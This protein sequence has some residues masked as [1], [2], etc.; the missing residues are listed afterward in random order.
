VVEFEDCT[1]TPNKAEKKQQLYNQRFYENQLDPPRVNREN[2]VDCL[3]WLSK[4]VVSEE[5]VVQI[6]I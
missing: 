1:L 5:S 6:W 2:I 4:R 3:P